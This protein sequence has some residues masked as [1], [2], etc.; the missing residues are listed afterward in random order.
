MGKRSVYFIGTILLTSYAFANYSG[1]NPQEYVR[2][3]AP[4]NPGASTF[5]NQSL[6]NN[7]L[8]TSKNIDWASLCANDLYRLETDGCAV[9][10]NSETLVKA[11]AKLFKNSQIEKYTNVSLPYDSDGVFIFKLNDNFAPITAKFTLTVGAVPSKGVGYVCELVSRDG[12]PASLIN[13]TF[14]SVLSTIAIDYHCKAASGS[15]CY[16]NKY[17]NFMSQ[18]NISAPQYAWYKNPRQP[19]YMVCLSYEEQDSNPTVLQSTAGCNGTT[20]VCV[21]YL[22]Q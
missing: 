3:G 8:R 9:D 7:A 15:T 5:P 17:A 13:T 14:F 6:D 18:N 21:S 22:L 10:C 20:G 11:C 19:T 4:M 1:L 16:S 2:N 12:T